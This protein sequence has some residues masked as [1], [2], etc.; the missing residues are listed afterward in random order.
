MRGSGRFICYAAW[1]RRACHGTSVGYSPARWRRRGSHD[2]PA[3]GAAQRP[4]RPDD[5]RAPWQCRQADRRRHPHRV[6]SMVD[7]V[8][9]A[10]ELQRGLDERN[11]VCRRTAASSS[12]S[13]FI[14]ATLSR[15]VDARSPSRNGRRRERQLR[16]KQRSFADCAANGSNRPEAASSCIASC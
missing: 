6:R 5:R 14:L 1:Y 2:G 9:C 11:A 12:A 13:A 16:A 10:V 8:R 7:A 15:R 4:D 3:P